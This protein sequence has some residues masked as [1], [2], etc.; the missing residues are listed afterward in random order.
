MK[1]HTV[2]LSDREGSANL[3]IPV[4]PSGVEHDASASIEHGKFARAR[5]E[6]VLLR[7]LDS[8]SFDHVSLIKIDVE[9]HEYSVLQGAKAT[10][11]NSK[12]ALLIEIEQRH[13]VRPI[14]EV[15]RELMR[16]GYRGFFLRG[17]HLVTINEFDRVPRP[18]D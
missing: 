1:I 9:G 14:A 11:A 13:S 5:K 16:V 3:L 8:F 18:G 2:A 15:F 4:D 12:P 17:R 10:L 7:T 6:L